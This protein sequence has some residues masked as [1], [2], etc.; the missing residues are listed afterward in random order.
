MARNN[1]E[2]QIALDRANQ[3]AQWAYEDYKTNLE[4]QQKVN[5]INSHNAH[6][7]ASVY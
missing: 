7:M 3:Q 5:E 1:E 2:K 6:M 4:R